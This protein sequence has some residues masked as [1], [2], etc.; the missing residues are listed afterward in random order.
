[1]TAAKRQAVRRSK[2]RPVSVVLTNPAAIAAHDNLK[3][4]LGGPKKAIEHAL[5]TCTKPTKIGENDENEHG[6]P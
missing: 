2:G 5:K 4:A 6:R 3:N 1:M